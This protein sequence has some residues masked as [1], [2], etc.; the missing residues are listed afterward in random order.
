MDTTDTKQAHT[1][2]QTIRYRIAVEVWR[3]EYYLMD[4]K[5]EEEAI[6]NYW[7]EGKQDESVGETNRVEYM[8]IEV[9]G[10]DT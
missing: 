9:L 8:G 7:E 4:A 6:A 1:P 5:N 3:T 10:D 2:E